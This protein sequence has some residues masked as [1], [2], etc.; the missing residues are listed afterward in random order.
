MVLLYVLEYYRIVQIKREFFFFLN[1]PKSVDPCD[2]WKFYNLKHFLTHRRRRGLTP[3]A[4]TASDSEKI[5]AHL[6]RLVS[7]ISSN[8][9]RWGPKTRILSWIQRWENLIRYFQFAFVIKNP[10]QIKV[11]LFLKG[12]LDFISSPMTFFSRAATASKPRLAG[13]QI[14]FRGTRLGFV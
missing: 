8:Q 14:L 5:G 2:A 7:F 1:C 4:L 6:R 3:E 11:K 12:G 13:N 9:S 10:N